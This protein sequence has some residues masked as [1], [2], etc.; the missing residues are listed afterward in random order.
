VHDVEERTHD[1][2]LVSIILKAPMK[3][4]KYI[5]YTSNV[6]MVAHVSSHATE[7]KYEVF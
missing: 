3:H 5:P 7:D 1:H 6:K 2:Y 4:E